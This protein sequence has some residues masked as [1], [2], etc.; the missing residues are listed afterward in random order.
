MNHSKLATA[1]WGVL[2]GVL[3]LIGGCAIAVVDPWSAM[4]CRITFVDTQSGAI[5]RKDY[6]LWVNVRTTRVETCVS[7]EMTS[8][9]S[10]ASNP[11][12][13]LRTVRRLSPWINNS[14]SYKF[15]AVELQLSLLEMLWEE[16]RFSAPARV[17]SAKCLLAAWHNSDELKAADQYLKRLAKTMY[18]LEEAGQ[19]VSEA[20]VPD[21]DG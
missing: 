17:Q 2:L 11:Q 21:C 5:V 7:Q 10:N 1:R 18:A 4:C 12:A 16:G 13:R 14:P 15:G 19:P 9:F 8:V 3:L 20:D 6:L